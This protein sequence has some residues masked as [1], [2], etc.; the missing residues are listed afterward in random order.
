M[1]TD[2]LNLLSAQVTIISSLVA[3]AAVSICTIISAVITQRGAKKA[4]QTELIFHEMVMAYYDFLR[5]C[6]EFSDTN[7]PEQISRF[8]DA[9]MR[10][11]LF[12]SPDTQ[13]L[14]A[15]YGNSVT[16]VLKAK[17]SG[18]PD[19]LKIAKD[20]GTIKGLLLKSMQKD[21]RK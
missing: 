14:I 7:A 21:L 15:R 13:D 2:L 6:D 20:T 5:A 11:L 10:A 12:S 4:K 18:D 17:E 3:I 19:I 16:R 1:K 8:S 9:S